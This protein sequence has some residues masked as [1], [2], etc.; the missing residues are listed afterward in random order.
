MVVADPTWEM[1]GLADGGTVSRTFGALLRDLR[2]RRALT[3]ADIAAKVGVSRATFTQW[4]TGRHLPI[5]QR[6]HELDRLLDADGELVAAAEQLRPPPRVGPFDTS[7]SNG[8]ARHGS[9]LRVLKDIRRALLDQLQCDGPGPIGWRHNLVH[10]DETPSTLSTA[11]GLK[12][13]ALSGGPAACNTALVDQVVNKALRSD[14]GRLVGW[15]ARTQSQ[16][17]LETTASVLDA[18]L[19]AGVSLPVDDVLR[20]LGDLVDDTTTQRPFV[21]TAALE[22]LLRVAPDSG[23]AG[24]LVRSLL[25]CRVDFGDE[26]LW[27]EKLLH[28]D[29]PLLA[30]SVAHTARAVTVLRDAPPELL[31]DAVTSAEQWIADVDDM[32]AVT[33]TIRRRLDAEKSENLTIHHFTSAWVV[34]AL[35]GGAAPLGRRIEHALRHVWSRYDEKSHF[36]AWGNG[37]VPVWMLMDAVTAL[38]DAA[39][40]LSPSMTNDYG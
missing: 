31:G 1:Q 7:S 19:H 34:R 25:G 16:P 38:R 18:L 3:Q 32:N 13:L 5:S 4:E 33:E 30:P 26:L 22:P 11:Y 23:L 28:R 24:E 2:E 15:A 20:M 14:D 6:L 21:L 27:P 17:R 9:V 37:D 40:A 39:L 36:W 10:S 35:A 8:G 12:V 29:Q